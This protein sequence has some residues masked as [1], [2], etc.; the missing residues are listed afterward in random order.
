MSFQIINGR[1]IEIL[2]DIPESK[3]DMSKPKILYADNSG[4][5]HITFEENESVSVL[6]KRKLREAFAKDG[7]EGI[8]GNFDNERYGQE[9]PNDFF[10]N[11]I[12]H[13]VLPSKNIN[14]QNKP[15]MNQ[16]EVDEIIDWCYKYLASKNININ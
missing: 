11:N 14:E 6:G 5:I 8:Y 3:W 9:I 12:G 4:N 13:G 10:K 15:C 1:E 16:A 7:T 2:E